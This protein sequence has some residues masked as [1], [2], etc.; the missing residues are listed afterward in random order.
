M[1]RCVCLEDTTTAA[2]FQRFQHCTV[3]SLTPRHFA[4]TNDSNLGTRRM[5]CSKWLPLSTT[6][7]RAPLRTNVATYWQL[8][9]RRSG[10]HI[11]P[12]GSLGYL[13]STVKTS[14]FWNR[15]FKLEQR[16]EELPF[17][18]LKPIAG[19]VSAKLHGPCWLVF[20][21][22]AL[23]CTGNHLPV[24]IPWDFVVSTHKPFVGSMI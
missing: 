15:M 16:V 8:A 6:P 9:I 19:L 12:L 17:L 23:T 11:G 4:S 2:N 21:G 18:N 7:I 24:P 22:L 1:S 3:R 5:Q 20:A 14:L 10:N 13:K